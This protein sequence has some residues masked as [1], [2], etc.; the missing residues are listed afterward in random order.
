MNFC[1]R[2]NK[3][4]E[5]E[6]GGCAFEEDGGCR[7]ENACEDARIDIDKFPSEDIVFVEVDGKIKYWNVCKDF[8]SS[9]EKLMKWHKMMLGGE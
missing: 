2:C 8:D 1:E 6:D 7:I 3:H 4:K 5:R 9:D